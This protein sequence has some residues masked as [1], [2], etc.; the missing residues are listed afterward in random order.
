M[1]TEMT[2]DSGNPSQY[3]KMLTMLDKGVTL[4]QFL[5]LKEAEQI[6]GYLRYLNAEGGRNYGISPETFIEYRTAIKGAD[7]DESGSVS[8]TEAAEA[9]R[10]M[11]KG[12]ATLT[13]SGAALTNRQKAV[14]WQLTNKSWKPYG[15]PFDTAVGQQVYDALHAEP[16]PE[17][18][19]LG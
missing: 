17:R 15:N 2:T 5:D 12:L 13:G 3:A 14:L 18:S 6:D 8:K 1:G 7:T 4:D 19:L 9:I 11:G 10:E 16:E